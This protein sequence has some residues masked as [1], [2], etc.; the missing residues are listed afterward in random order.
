[1][2]IKTFSRNSEE[3]VM[4]LRVLSKKSEFSWEVGVWIRGKEGYESDACTVWYFKNPSITWY[5]LF[6]VIWQSF[7]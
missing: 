4:C 7:P 6:L 3:N 5:L 1:M 2:L